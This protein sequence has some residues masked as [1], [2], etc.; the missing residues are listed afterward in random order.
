[1]R[2]IVR[3]NVCDGQ[4]RESCLHSVRP[5][6]NV[7]HWIHLSS[8]NTKVVHDNS[9]MIYFYSGTSNG[10]GRMESLYHRYKHQFCKTYILFHKAS[11]RYIYQMNTANGQLLCDF[12]RSRIADET[13]QR[14]ISCILN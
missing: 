8:N 13:S 14:A 7:R 10:K 4:F 6:H 1:M 3:G 9:K 12:E 5:W 2:R 11:P